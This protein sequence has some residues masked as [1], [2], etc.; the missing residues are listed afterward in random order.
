MNEIPIKASYNDP[1]TLPI[2]RRNETMFSID[3]KE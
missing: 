1:Y 3:W 2:L